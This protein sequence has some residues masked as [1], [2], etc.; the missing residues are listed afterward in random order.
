[1]Q[2]IKSSRKKR[3]K[4]E[5]QKHKEVQPMLPWKMLLHH[6]QSIQGP[7]LCAKLQSRGTFVGRPQHHKMVAVMKHWHNLYYNKV[8]K[9][10]YWVLLNKQKK[11]LTSCLYTDCKMNQNQCLSTSGQQNLFQPGN[12]VT[13]AEQFPH[14]SL[15]SGQNVFTVQSGSNKDSYFWH[16][17]SKKSGEFQWLMYSAAH[18]YLPFLDRWD[19][20][21]SIGQVSPLLRNG[22]L[23]S[24]TA[25]FF[26]PSGSQNVRSVSSLSGKEEVELCWAPPGTTAK[27]RASIS[28]NLLI[29]IVKTD[30]LLTKM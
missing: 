30:S 23:C 17:L 26:V 21:S 18:F 14:S 1:M 9:N 7:R 27:S 16:H 4:V 6:Y 28:W 22:S 3:K 15:L 13:L 25:L 8:S 10:R 19:Q 12:G 29:H 5:L 2:N 24:E 20:C 11:L